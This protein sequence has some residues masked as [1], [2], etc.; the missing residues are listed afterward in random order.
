M[1]Q[2]TSLFAAALSCCAIL[3]AGCGDD[4]TSAAGGD[5]SIAHDL[6]TVGSA[7]TC[8]AYCA[9]IQMN[10]TAGDGGSNVQYPD[11]TTCTSYCTTAAGW[12]AGASSDVM[13]NTIGCRLYHAGAAAADPVLH[14][15]HAGPTGGNV[16]GAWCENYCQLMAKNCTGANAVYTASDCMTKCATIP[17]MGMV[18]DTTGNTVQCRIYHLGAAASD[19]ATHCVHSRTVTDPMFSGPCM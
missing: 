10:C 4:T 2:P 19:P 7:P 18:N 13:G 8:A 3:T 15:P 5:M 14:C 12:T 16:C 11:A 6:A 1:R 17:T 9:K